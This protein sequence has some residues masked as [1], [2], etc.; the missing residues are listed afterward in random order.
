MDRETT[1]NNAFVSE[2]TTIIDT[3][4]F[5]GLQPGKWY[6]LKGILMDKST[7]E[8]F[9]DDGEEVST[10]KTFRAFAESGAVTLEFTFNSLLLGGKSVVVFEYLHY[11][12]EIIAEHADIEDEGQTVTFFGPKI[13]TLATGKD[14]NKIIPLDEE[15]V[16]IDTV[17]YENLVAGETYT[18]KGILMDKETGKPVLVDGKEIT[19]EVTFVAEDTSGSAEVEFIFDSTELES[20]ILVVFEYLYYDGRLIAEHTDIND[21]EQTVT[22]E[23]EEPPPEPEPTPTPTP[24]PEPPPKSPQTGREGLPIWL[25]IATAILTI[26]AVVAT[27]YT[28]KRW[29]PDLDE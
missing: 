7:G 26:A 10:I 28:I 17:S 18:I 5:S 4:Y 6:T 20:M 29:K 11:G 16:V 2:T 9:L 24:T 22:V 14:G 1:T 19:S 23:S 15:A 13:G 21:E 25:L 27:V 8:P 12:D 3:V